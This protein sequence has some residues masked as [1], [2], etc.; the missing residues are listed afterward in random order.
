MQKM[1]DR[2]EDLSPM[3]TI[4]NELPLV[5]SEI[6]LHKTIFL[7]MVTRFGEASRIEYMHRKCEKALY[8]DNQSLIPSYFKYSFSSYTTKVVKISEIMSITHSFLHPTCSRF[9]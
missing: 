1:K 6:M 5:T 2:L 4:H 8:I 3:K 7:N 9:V